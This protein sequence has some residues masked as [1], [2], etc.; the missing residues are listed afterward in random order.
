MMSNGVV[1]KL[2]RKISTKKPLR[3]LLKDFLKLKTN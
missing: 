3:D 1:F 2:N